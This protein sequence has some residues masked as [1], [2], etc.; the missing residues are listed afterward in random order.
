MRLGPGGLADVEGAAVLAAEGGSDPVL[1]LEDAAQGGPACGLTEPGE[2]SADDLYELVGEDGDEQ[3]S[4]GTVLLL[5]EDGAQAEF[6]LEGAEHGFEIG[7]HGVGAPEGF[8]IP[9]TEIGAQAV[10]TRMS[11]HGARAGLALPGDGHGLAALRVGHHVNLVML[12]GPSALFLDAPD[13]LPD[14]G[15]ALAGSGPG[16]PL[17]EL[18]QRAFEACG[19]AF[20]DAL[21]L[22][23]SGL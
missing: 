6:G 21:F 9:V 23:G 7:E 3:V 11:E 8:L 22:L 13:A 12:R 1:A 2:A 14:M 4:V 18:L 10:D 16:E 19:E 15:E 20:G 17:M 5:V